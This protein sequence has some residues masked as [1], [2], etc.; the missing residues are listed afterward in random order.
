[1]FKSPLPRIPAALSA[2]GRRPRLFGV[3]VFVGALGSVAAPRAQTVAFNQ[4]G[5]T[6]SGAISDQSV[7]TLGIGPPAQSGTVAGGAQIDQVRQRANPIALTSD[8]GGGRTQATADT[9]Y[10]PPP[11]IPGPPQGEFERYVQATLGRR[12]TR[13]GTSILETRNGYFAP[14]PTAAVPDDYVLRPGD[15][16]VL[17]L[18]GSIQGDMRLSVD[19]DG[20][21]FVPRVGAISVV[22]VPYSSLSELLTSRIGEQFRGFH[23]SVVIGRL[24]GIRIYV[25]G[26]ALKPGAYTLNSLSTLVNAIVAAGG[27]SASGSFRSVQLRRRGSVVS[28]F[29]TYELLLRGDKTHDV[30][31]QDGDVIYIAPVGPQVAVTG[32]VN[33]EAI[34]EAK[35]GE[36]FQDLLAFAGGP[37]SVADRQHVFALKL[38]T[39]D[40]AGWEELPFASI[41]EQPVEPGAIYKIVSDADIVH[42]IERQS[43]L[44]KLD[45]EI[46]HP[47]RYYLRPGS[48]IADLMAEAGG[49]T[50]RA[51]V[52]GTEIDRSSVQR[53]QQ[54]AFDEAIRDT[55]LA[56][57]AVPLNVRG[58]E[59]RAQELRVATAEAVLERLR[60]EKPT[61]RVI[62]S[63]HA[64]SSVL[65]A[66]FSLENDDSIHV[67]SVPITVG[68]FG[69]VYRAGSFY[70]ASPRTV[71]EYL[72]LAGG[73]ERM[74]D[75]GAIFVVHAN[76]AVASEHPGL[77]GRSVTSEIA[78]PGDVIFVP[79]RVE[80]NTV[81]EKI[82]DV[83]SLVYQFGLGAAALRVLS[84]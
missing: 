65:P 37:D 20:R 66:A 70:D 16:L 28:N 63:L 40:Q 81:F 18:T 77:F 60:Q 34:Y 61:G 41:D 82:E 64:S 78:L 52:F 39:V 27:P 35:P 29:D 17:R 76:G 38:S 67:P 9:Q 55:Q 56:L 24:H 80:T 5:T 58:V 83:A 12:L 45:G 71:G 30:T 6:P 59:A 79:V 32:S 4:N 33:Q 44:V 84:Q 51:Y 10:P 75:K 42:P 48:T 25:T 43:I 68:V 23:L 47:G 19:R 21:I 14:S 50:P 74:A 11:R 31:L 53:Q 8:G 2:A 36:T 49:L 54:R 13:F 7:S 46:Q 72:R 1:M 57:T 26:Y 3:L 15:E 69:A 62:L 22:G 73:P